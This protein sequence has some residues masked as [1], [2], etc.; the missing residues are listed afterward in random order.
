MWI[1]DHGIRIR[2]GYHKNSVPA[3]AAKDNLSNASDDS[4]SGL[5][6]STTTQTSTVTT[7]VTTSVTTVATTTEEATGDEGG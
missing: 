3:L 2:H 5:A 4:D 6:T 1:H 7:S